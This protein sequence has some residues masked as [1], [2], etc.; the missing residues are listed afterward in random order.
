MDME[1][2]TFFRVTFEQSVFRDATC[3]AM[4]GRPRFYHRYVWQPLVSKD[5]QVS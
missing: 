2:D 4:V 5:S 1:G 3:S